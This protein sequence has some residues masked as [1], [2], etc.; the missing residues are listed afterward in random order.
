MTE[1]ALRCERVSLHF[2][3]VSALSEVS[4][5]VPQGHVVGLIGPNGAGKSSLINC[6]TG[7]YQPQEGAIE[8][9]GSPVVGLSPKQIAL[10][11][12]SR[13]FQQA[14]SLA[15]M[16][17]RD[18][19]MLGRDRFLPSG[20][21]RYAVPWPSTFRAERAS[22][23]VVDA[24]GDEL[25]IGADVRRNTPYQSLPYG[26]R[27]LVDLGRALAC[28]P[29]ILLMDEP[30]A[31]LTDS[32]KATMAGVIRGIQQ[33]RGIAQLL[34][35]HD[36]AFV[37]SLTGRLVVLDAGRLIAEG[38]TDDVLRNQEVID[39]YIGRPEV[40]VPTEVAP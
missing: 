5:D 11:G 13:T 40:D 8:V 18:V 23:A 22:R 34:V 6:I 3:G 17:A 30:A 4:F 32:E 35:D 31:G 24:L 15:G 9:T 25:G 7:F 39:S 26:V 33:N 10:S 36:L 27:K 21:L 28:E 19:M 14:E 37:S 38:P 29:S 2:G 20:F 1:I 16:G 12:V